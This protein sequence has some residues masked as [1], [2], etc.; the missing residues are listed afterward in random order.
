MSKKP[1]KQPD[2][3]WVEATYNASIKT[4]FGLLGRDV[5]K[6]VDTRNEQLPEGGQLKFECTV[7][8]REIAI[9]RRA[10]HQ[11]PEGDDEIFFSLRK[12]EIWVRG[13]NT[14]DIG[15][16]TL[17]PKEDGTCRYYLRRSE[18]DP[19]DLGNALLRWQVLR[20]ILRSLFF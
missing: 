17:E 18:E 19:V 10:W 16:I 12:N 9:I 11:M 13:D 5:A 20:L 3:N 7:G 6:L 2:F 15:V 1:T 8:S 4:Q 14:G